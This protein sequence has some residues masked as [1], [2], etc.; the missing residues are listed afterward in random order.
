MKGH[1][2]QRLLLLVMAIFALATPAAAIAQDPAQNAYGRDTDVLG[3]IGEVN[4]EPS[5][6]EP[7]A[8]SEPAAAAPAPAPVAS[9]S[10]TLPFTG[11]DALLLSVGG[12]MLLAAGLA[13]R[14]F[15]RNVA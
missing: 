4:E 1:T 6:E 7:A 3:E 12:G 9:E 11:T 14:R 15:S 10:N 13:L 2:V 5:Q 8:A